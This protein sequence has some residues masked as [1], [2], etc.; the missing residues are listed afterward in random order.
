MVAATTRT[1]T[2][3]GLVA[4]DALELVL[5]EHAQHLRLR[6]E[7][8]VAD[9]VEEAACRRRPPRTCPRGAR[10]A[11]VKAPFSCPKS[12]LSTS[13]RLIAAQFIATNGLRAARAAVVERLRDQLLAGA[14]LAADEHRE[15]GVGDPVDGLEHPAHR[16]AGADDAARSRTSRCTCSSS[17]RCSR[18]EQHAFDHARARRGGSRRCRTASARSPSAPSFIASTAI[19]SEPCAVIMITA[20][21]GSNARARSSTSMPL[22]PVHAEIGEHEVEAAGLD[23]AQRLFARWPRS[24]PRSPPC[25]AGRAARAGSPSRRRRSGCVRPSRSPSGSLGHRQR[26]DELGAASQLAGDV[27]RAAVRLDDLPRDR[28]AE[29]GAVLLRGEERVEDALELVR[30]GCRG[31]CR[32][33]A[34]SR[35]CPPFS[36]K[37]ST[38]AALGHRRR[39]RRSRC[40]SG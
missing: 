6:L 32:A 29:P 35:C 8:H 38:R 7:R 15:V 37:S 28:Q 25:G 26:D 34:P 13:S 20:R 23:L 36:M 5:L 12:S 11:P 21:S 9:L 33:R 40:R 17:R 2:R 10:S 30:P 24:R 16:R 27:D 14:A 19:F 18:A 39:A 31:R 1:S 3:I 4:A 22:D